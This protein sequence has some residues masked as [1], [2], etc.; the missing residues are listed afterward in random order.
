MSLNYSFNIMFIM[1][2]LINVIVSYLLIK[3]T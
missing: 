3:Y 2:K 1:S